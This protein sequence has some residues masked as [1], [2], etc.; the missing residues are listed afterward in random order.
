MANVPIA[1]R[2]E[3]KSNASK[4]ESSI[5][6]LNGE[7]SVDDKKGQSPTGIVLLQRFDVSA[8]G[9][10]NFD[11]RKRRL[12]RCNGPKNLLRSALPAIL[13]FVSSASNCYYFRKFFK[14]CGFF[15]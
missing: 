15:Q 4:G 8:F 3:A 6:R 2:A 11:N 13:P 14:N 12:R 7:T 1:L 10:T 9:L 5:F